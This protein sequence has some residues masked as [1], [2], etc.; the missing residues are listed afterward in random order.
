MDGGRIVQRHIYDTLFKIVI[1]GDSD[2]GKSA[3]VARFVT[4]T[5]PTLRP[6]HATIGKDAK[7]T[8]IL[9]MFFV[10]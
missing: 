2:V 5:D 8:V 6:Y 10:V 9:V 4:N 1:I 3:T 7:W